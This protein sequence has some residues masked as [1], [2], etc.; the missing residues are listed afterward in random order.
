MKSVNLSVN[1][2]VRHPDRGYASFISNHEQ[3][4]IKHRHD[5]FE[6]FLVSQGHAMHCVNDQRL[7]LNTGDLVLMRP[8]DEHFYENPSAKFRII[9]MIITVETMNAFFLFLGDGFHKER[10]LDSM[11]P[12]ILHLGM[13][14]LNEQIIDFEELVMSKIVM[15]EKSDTFFRIVLFNIMT[16]MFPVEPITETT[17]IPDWLQWL[18]LEMQ[19]KENFKQG[20]STFYALSGRSEAH[21]SRMCHKHLGKTPTQLINEIRLDYAVK[22]LI[23]TKLSATAI[24]ETVGFESVSHFFH[25]FKSFYKVPPNVY[26]REVASTDS[27]I[28]HSDIADKASERTIKEGLP[29]SPILNEK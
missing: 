10:V 13:N 27:S 14:E 29:L 7:K 17:N 8:N 9:N 23:G 11:L 12:P 19:K 5:Y 26:R 3:L 15:R 24:S 20:I 22:L 28:Y 25:I 21:V 16:K 4:K 18:V 2:F 1:S 6:L